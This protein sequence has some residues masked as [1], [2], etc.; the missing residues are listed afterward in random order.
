MTDL[1]IVNDIKAPGFTPMFD[2]VVEQ[3]AYDLQKQLETFRDAK[4]GLRLLSQKMGIHEKTLGR[5]LR[6]ENKPGYQ[7][8]YKIYRCLL[9]EK[10]DALLLERMPQVIREA[11]R[12]GNPKKLEANKSYTLNVLQELRQNTVFQELYFLCACHPLSAD[13]IKE[14]YGLKGMAIL[15]RMLELQVLEESAFQNYVLGRNQTNIDAEGLNEEAY[16]EWL[17]I[18]EEAF[19]K[20]VELSKL[21][22]SRGSLR[23][24]T[25]ML[26]EKMKLQNEKDYE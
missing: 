6:G 20:K 10:D 3:V 18:D 2:S 14:Q 22:H 7:T 12:K 4:I 19:A 26:T 25:F 16:A 5:L 9:N 11:I 8:L 13:Q 1:I 23:A 24:M 17:K 21:G 15:E